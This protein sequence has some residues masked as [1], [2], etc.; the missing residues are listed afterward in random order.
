MPVRTAIFDF[1]GT[2]ADTV[3][4]IVRV[5]NAIAPEFQFRTADGA[6]VELLRG[7]PARQIAERL[8]LGWQK[9]PAIVARVR[10][11]M[12]ANM[13]NVAPCSGVPDALE[14]LRTA[15]VTLGL[16]TSNNRQN[17]DAFLARH[18]LAFDFISTGSGLWSK[19]RRLA[20]IARRRGL[21]ASETAYIGDETRDIEAARTLGMHAIAV[22]WGFTHAKLLAEAGPDRLIS[23]PDQLAAA[24]GLPA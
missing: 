3:A 2:I 12:H 20:S 13:V 19:H 18:P 24:L 6:E 15:G 7:L 5:L 22:D 23:S 14:G 16:L 8:G 11:E 10:K 17:V 21:V 1:D 9:L 4:E